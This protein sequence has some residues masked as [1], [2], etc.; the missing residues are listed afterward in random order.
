MC[1]GGGGRVGV[2]IVNENLEYEIFL[3]C[4]T[5]RFNIPTPASQEKKLL[6]KMKHISN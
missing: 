3:V 5:Y 6:M 2:I 4:I 1:G